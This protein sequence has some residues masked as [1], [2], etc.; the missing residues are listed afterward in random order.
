MKQN[1][2]TTDRIV[3]S[4]IAVI[5]FALYYNDIIPG[6]LG[7]VLVVISVVFLLTSFISFCP[8]Y[9]ILG[10]TTLRKKKGNA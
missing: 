3:R 1:M 10:I 5:F 9:S 2:G 7:I 8:L 4:I 6:T